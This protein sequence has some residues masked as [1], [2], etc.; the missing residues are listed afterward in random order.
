MR[1]IPSKIKGLKEL[2]LPSVLE[3]IAGNLRGL[4]LVTGAT[5]QG[6]SAT[7]AAMI[8]YI[9]KIRSCHIITIE[10]PIEYITEDKR[11]IINQREV[12]IDTPNFASGLR[13]A[14][15]QDPDVIVIGEMRDRE[16]ISTA[17]LAAETGHLVFSTLHTVD[18]K[19]T[20][21]RIMATFPP[22]DQIQLRFQLASVLEAVV[23][24]RLLRRAD[25]QGLA[26][27]VEIMISTPRIKE[28]I[29]D[30]LASGEIT[31]AIAQG[32]TNYGMQTFDQSIMFL[33][34]KKIINYEEAINN[35]SNP[36][37]FALKL[38]GID[39]SSDIKWDEFILKK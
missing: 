25:G 24:Q 38:R 2:N 27:A 7:L 39:G 13:S 17:L 18:A 35:C 4:I 16:T 29:R 20:I 30:G 34:Q 37:D 14:L 10:D 9:N 33:Y 21:N 5:G 31:D 1:V 36:G 15:R 12:G 23:S 19:E 8:D 11:S 26:P 6:K 3:K 28:L 22:E 32:Y